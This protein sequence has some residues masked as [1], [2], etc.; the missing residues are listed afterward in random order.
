MDRL[1]RAVDGDESD[2]AVTVENDEGGP[3]MDFAHSA[4]P[5]QAPHPTPISLPVQLAK[6]VWSIRMEGG[7]CLTRGGKNT[8]WACTKPKG[9]M[10]RHSGVFAPGKTC[11]TIYPFNNK[12]THEWLE[13][14]VGGPETSVSFPVCKI[15]EKLGMWGDHNSPLEHL[16]HEYKAILVEIRN[17]VF[18]EGSPMSRFWLTCAADTGST[19]GPRT[20]IVTEL[21]GRLTGGPMQTLHF[22]KLF[23]SQCSEMPWPH[24]TF[25]T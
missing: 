16:P 12:E 11:S 5:A 7:D 23:A 22:L 20:R 2:D 15:G 14:H 13:I 8:D 1:S 10:G 9:H 3:A 4:Q 18:G 19:A 25:T 24:P 17:F 6:P 21:N